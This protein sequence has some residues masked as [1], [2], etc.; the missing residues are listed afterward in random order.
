MEVTEDDDPGIPVLPVQAAAAAAKVHAAQMW[1]QQLFL[2]G[3][4]EQ[5]ELRTHVEAIE[6]LLDRLQQHEI[7]LHP[8]GPIPPGPWQDAGALHTGVVAPHIEEQLEYE[9]SP[10]SSTGLSWPGSRSHSSNADSVSDYG[11]PAFIEAQPGSEGDDDGSGVQD[12][13]LMDFDEDDS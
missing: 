8:I 9:P 1:I 3:R 2:R 6:I 13:G 11:W 12:G 4:E 5:D 10:V 7:R